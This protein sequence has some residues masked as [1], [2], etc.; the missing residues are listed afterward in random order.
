MIREKRV[1]CVSWNEALAKSRELLLRSLGVTVLSALYEKEARSACREDADLLVLGHSVPKEE[2]R[3]IIR[4]FRGHSSAPVLS[5][6][7]T[8][9]TKLPEATFGV[10]SANP[11]EVLSVVRQILQN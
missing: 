6:L 10:E 5:L 11:E 9:D 3:S 7:R 8:G 1:I 4:C 2:K